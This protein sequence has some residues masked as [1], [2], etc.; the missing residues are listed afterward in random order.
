MI[1]ASSSLQ[2]SRAVRWKGAHNP[3]ECRAGSFSDNGALRI[4]YP[5]PLWSHRTHQPKRP[6]WRFC[7]FLQFA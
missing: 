3:T 7:R 6:G 1:S 5:A 4:F 2:P